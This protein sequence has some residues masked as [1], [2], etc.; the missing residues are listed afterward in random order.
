M[1]AVVCTLFLA[2]SLLIAQTKTHKIG[3][4]DYVPDEKTAIRIAEAVLIAQFGEAR[5]KEQQPL[6]AEGI[7]DVWLV[8]GT[9]HGEHGPGGNFG[10]YVQKHSGCVGIIEQMK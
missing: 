10:V 9:L 4:P 3:H 1:K 2:A 8:Q 7:Y 5:V 6:W